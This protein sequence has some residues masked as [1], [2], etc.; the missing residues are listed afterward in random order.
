MSAQT[1]TADAAVMLQAAV[2]QETVNG[3]L[4]SAITLYRR[5][6]EDR[7]ADRATVAKALV[8]LGR[9]YET[10]GQGEAQRAYQR[11]VNEFGDQTEQAAMARRR[12]AALV[13]SAPQRDAPVDGIT[14]KQLWTTRASL[15]INTVSPDGRRVAFVD[16]RNI[17]M[18]GLR[19]HADVAVY[20]LTT[21]RAS[22]ITDR[23]PQYLVDTY[24][25]DVI[26]SPD[27][28]RLAY[29]LWDTSWT[30]MDLY[31]VG[32]NGRDNRLL[33][34]NVQFAELQ[35]MAWSAA[36]GFIAASVKGWDDRYRIVLVSTR[37][38]STRVVKT[39]GGHAVH[40]I[41]ASP[42]GR[43]L[44]Y[45][46]H[47]GVGVTDHDL[48][49]LA[50]DGSSETPLAPHPADEP[51]GIFSPEGDRVLFLSRRSGQPGLWAIRV[52]DGRGT[53]EPEL[54][55]PDIGAAQL[56]GFTSTGALS[57][58]ISRGEANVFSSRLDLTGT[59]SLEG[60]EPLTSN[61]IG[62]N[63]RAVW[64]P[65]GSRVAFI[66]MRGVGI[67][68]P[69]LVVRAMD[70]GEERSHGLP[71]QVFNRATRPAW[72]ADG[73]GVLLEGGAT[74]DPAPSDFRRMT[75]RVDVSSGAIE[76]QPHLHHASGTTGGIFRF[77]T[78]R[79]TQRLGELGLRLFGQPDLQRFRN[80]DFTLA[81][82]EEPLLVREGVYR[83]P[84]GDGQDLRTIV[85]GHTHSW[86]LSPDGNTL[87]MVLPSDTVEAISRVLFV[88]P[89]TGGAG[90]LKEI[91]RAPTAD[92]EKMA[93]RWLPDGSGLLFVTARREHERGTLWHVAL[94][95]SAPRRL[96]VALSWQ[97]LAEL[98]F[99]P[100]GSGRVALT[101]AASVN[102]LWL[103]DGFS[104][105]RRASR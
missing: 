52:Q 73:S 102:E 87:A 34:N 35:P 27:G 7:R 91:A 16:W 30:H 3:N 43:F 74:G 66:S 98:D 105:Q 97:Q 93:V 12:L 68:E 36:G 89:V 48:F 94:D 41:S 77:A 25:A 72:T 28:Q 67:S 19:G 83:R 14:V 22:V 100:D 71:F 104:W 61:F 21:R 90:S 63:R 5:V 10:L 95:G 24:I 79:Q 37:D 64:S 1:R 11:V 103:M 101:M 4:D 49:L 13:A 80:G 65:D 69:H 62:R 85:Y 9:A 58:R 78:A 56:L 38:G 70:T 60:M 17:D 20:D 45:E 47:Q 23:P 51:H 15:G 76:P 84:A 53:G 29:S 54:V 2:H 81:P 46:Y 55:R 59:G 82:G 33:V 39:L 31:T 32:A 44:L 6:A 40:T 18:E 86:E 26:W 42:D 88:M 75:Y 57:Y 96:S 92:Q 99:A 8:S 50:S